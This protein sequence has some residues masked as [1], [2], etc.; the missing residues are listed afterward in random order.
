MHKKPAESAF[1]SREARVSFLR[2]ASHALRGV[3]TLAVLILAIAV[4]R[5]WYVHLPDME[6][7]RWRILLTLL[8]IAAGAWLARPIVAAGRRLPV[9]AVAVGLI[10][11]VVSQV[12][13]YVLVWGTWKSSGWLWRTWWVSLVIGFGAGHAAWA[14]LLLAGTDA[15]RGWRILLD[16]IYACIAIAALLVAGLALGQT[17]LPDISTAY[18]L[19]M[20]IPL[21]VAWV[22]TLIIWIRWWRLRA[23]EVPLWRKIGWSGLGIACVFALGFYAGRLT[24]P[25]LNVLDAMPAGLA[26]LSAAQIDTQLNADFRRLQIVATGLD[27]LIARSETLR[28][29]LHALRQ[30]EHRD[31]YRP[32]EEDQIRAA[33]MSYLAYRAALLRLAATYSRFETIPDPILRAKAFLIGYAAGTTV[34]RSSQHLII[35]YRDEEPARKKLNEP[36]AAAGIP[37]GE[38]ENIYRSVTDARNINRIMEMAAFYQTRREEWRNAKVLGA[39]DFGWIDDRINSSLEQIRQTRVD[40]TAATIDQFIRRVK[41]DGY[42]PIYA[43]QSVISTL[44]GDT[45]MV[46]RPP[47]I[48]LDQIRAMQSQLRPGDIFLERRNWFMSNA[49]LPGFWPHAALYI[50][51]TADMEKMELI[52]K[53]DGGWTSDHPSIREHLPELLAPAEDGEAHTVIESVSEGVIL[54]SLTESMHADYVAVLRPHR[55]SEAERAQAIVRAFGHVGKPYDFEFDFFSADKLVCTELVYRSY[56]GLIRFNLVPVMGRNTLP[57]MEIAKKFAAERQRDDRDLDFVLFLDAVP[58]QQA[59]RLANEAEF[60]QAIDR[61]KAFNE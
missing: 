14:R 25:P 59:A 15:A 40:G 56:D 31:F 13:F 22:G 46:S 9:G 11:I 18:Q 7:P 39:D 30:T 17:P 34:M 2:A 3:L 44:I 60:V 29:Q 43:A 52:R 19:A 51:T 38:F 61:P 32:A 54:N 37:G 42:S 21:A 27:D 58:D 36:D 6:D 48:R 4:V 28:Q 41:A 12:C 26:H 8:G 33:F 16:V 49:F 5:H 53:T 24:A 45:R 55:L 35:T 1:L 20:V 10:G 57:A 47:F 23:A 50:G